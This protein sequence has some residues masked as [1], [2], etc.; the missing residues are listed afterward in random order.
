MPRK[1]LLENTIC[2]IAS[3]LRLFNLAQIIVRFRSTLQLHYKERHWVKYRKFLLLQ[4][5]SLH[6][7]RKK[8]SLVVRFQKI[9]HSCSVPAAR[10]SR[11]IFT[12]STITNWTPSILN[13]LQGHILVALQLKTCSYISHFYR[14]STRVWWSSCYYSGWPKLHI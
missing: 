14:F 10:A 7:N 9:A 4:C 8:R 11:L 6:Q 13:L 1:A 5:S 12:C 3:I 2:P